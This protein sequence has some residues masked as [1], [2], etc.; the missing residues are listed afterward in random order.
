MTARVKLD[1]CFGRGFRKPDD[2]A[3]GG[4]G[5]CIGGGIVSGQA[6]EVRCVGTMI[7]FSAGGGGH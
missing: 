7:G 5:G 6:D 4:S 1:F 3:S 2:P